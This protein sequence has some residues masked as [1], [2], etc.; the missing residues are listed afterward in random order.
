MKKTLVIS[1]I[2]L[3]QGINSFAQKALDKSEEIKF[4]SRAEAKH[5]EKGQESTYHLFRAVDAQE[6]ISEE[7][8]L[9][10][11]SYLDQKQAKK[12][13][14]IALL[15]S[16]FEK[17]NRNLFKK[18][19]QHSTFNAMLIEGTFDCVSGSAALAMLLNRYGFDFEII[20]T[21]YH[22]F[23]V[24]HF[25]DENIIFE[26]TL[27]IGGMIISNTKV[28]KYLEGYKTTTTAQ[29]YTLNQR[30]DDPERV[31]EDKS[32]FRKVSLTQLAGLQYYNDAISHFNEQYFSEASLQLNK[33]LELY[34]SP[35]IEGL[36]SLAIE[37]AYKTFGKDIK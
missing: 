9:N 28:I 32:I 8:W 27:P 23:I 1:F 22:V 4:T 36:K 31:L 29:F 33:A 5:W 35:R 6:D 18:Y 16:I 15:R 37:Q 25:E 26:S 10:L 24:A 3:V 34:P 19:E 21:D 13:N 7:K 12:G 30:L 2:L 11:I 17:T 20:E 14:S